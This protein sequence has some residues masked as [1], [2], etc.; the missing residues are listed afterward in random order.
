MQCFKVSVGQSWDLTIPCVGKGAVL[1]YSPWLFYIIHFVAVSTFF[2]QVNNY[3]LGFLLNWTTKQSDDSSWHW[4]NNKGQFYL[5]FFRTQMSEFIFSTDELSLSLKLDYEIKPDK[6]GFITIT[7]SPPVVFISQW[8]TFSCVTSP[9]WCCS[10]CHCTSQ[11]TYPR[12]PTKIQW[13][14]RN[15][16]KKKNNKKK[17]VKLGGHF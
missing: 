11:K 16:Q 6:S 14:S 12:R 3:N 2:S 17:K 5:S 1:E 15:K 7:T 8:P 9:P 13:C 10:V 4:V